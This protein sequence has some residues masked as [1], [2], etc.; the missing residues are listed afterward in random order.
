MIRQNGF[1][2]NGKVSSFKKSAKGQA[3]FEY[4]VLFIMFA[5]FCLLAVSGSNNGVFN[6]AR[7]SIE[8]IYRKAIGGN[9]GVNAR[10]G[11]VYDANTPLPAIQPITN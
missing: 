4:F 3:T 1:F 11:I 7:S 10:D 6:Q 8:D 2:I 5:F 9:D